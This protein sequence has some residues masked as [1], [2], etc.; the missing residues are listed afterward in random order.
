MLNIIEGLLIKMAK[1]YIND[2]N[3][4]VPKVNSKLMRTNF[5]LMNLRIGAEG[6][7]A[8]LQWE[9]N[10]S[11]IIYD[12]TGTTAYCA[13]FYEKN[14][15]NR[16]Y[17]G[18]QATDILQP[19][20]DLNQTLTFDGNDYLFQQTTVTYADGVDWS[21]SVYVKWTGSYPPAL[22]MMPFGDATSNLYEFYFY[23]SAVNPYFYIRNTI[24]YLVPNVPVATIFNGNWHTITIAVKNRNAIVYVDGEYKGETNMVGD[25]SMKFNGIGRGYSNLAYPT[26]TGNINNYLLFNRAL[27]INE[28]KSIHKYNEESLIY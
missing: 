2:I 18:K 21:F 9:V 24:T 6:S 12:Y 5:D 26:W 13:G 22:A 1:Y 14:F 11:N 8:F 25:S 19:S 23:N 28:V 15:A 10:K 20:Y 7:A 17:S 4:N 3:N 16:S 27:N